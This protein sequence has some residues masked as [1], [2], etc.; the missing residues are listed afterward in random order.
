MGFAKK[1]RE[2]AINLI[3]QNYYSEKLDNRYIGK[4]LDIS[5]NY[6]SSIFKDYLG[7]SMHQYLTHVKIENAK[8]LILAGEKNFSEIS[9]ELG[10]SSI[11]VFSKLFKKQVGMTPSEYI[12]T[13]Y[14]AT[15]FIATEKI[16]IEITNEGCTDENSNISQYVCNNFLSSK[17][18]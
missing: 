12:A 6:L 4:K 2:K 1:C 3:N 8:K 7:V 17:K 5:P 15:N 16:L 11:H 13:N 10:F 9:L 14:T 18:L